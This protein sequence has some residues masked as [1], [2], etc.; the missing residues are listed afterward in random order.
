MTLLYKPTD[1]RGKAS[2]RLQ[3]PNDPDPGRSLS[4]VAELFTDKPFR[5]FGRRYQYSQIDDLHIWEH[6]HPAGIVFRI[7]V[8][9]PVQPVSFVLSIWDRNDRLLEQHNGTVNGIM[10]TLIERSQVVISIYGHGG[11]ADHFLQ[12]DGH[13]R[14]HGR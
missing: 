8:T 13:G 12:I 3:F 2:E 10:R 9:D 14:S 5:L 6:D 7:E 4:A 1:R 11:T